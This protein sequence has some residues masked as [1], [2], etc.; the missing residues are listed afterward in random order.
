MFT[1]IIETIGEVVRVENDKTNVHFTVQSKI[2]EKLKI[3]QSVSHQGVCLT[4]IDIKEDCHTVTAIKETLDKSNLNDWKT[5]TLINL[6]RCTQLGER[7]DGHIVQG[8]VDTT[9]KCIKKEE[10]NGS[11]KF[12][13]KGENQQIEKLTVDKGSI[14]INGVSLT[15]VQSEKDQFSVAIIPYTFENTTFHQIEEGSEVNI[16]FDIVGKYVSKMMNLR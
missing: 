12:T 7:L 2:S 15:I 8:H 1:G 11:W 10:L 9:A 3:D 13:F 5:G 16:E 14:S 6:E 4:V